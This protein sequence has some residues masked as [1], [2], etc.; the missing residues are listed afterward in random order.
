[1][2]NTFNN[3]YKNNFTETLND[4]TKILLYNNEILTESEIQDLV[5]AG[6]INSSQ[7]LY[8]NNNVI[9]VNDRSNAEN[10]LDMFLYAK[11]KNSYEKLLKTPRA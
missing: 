7:E 10:N 3:S 8:E 5:V 11:D 6:S 9:L 4:S 1:M 2:G